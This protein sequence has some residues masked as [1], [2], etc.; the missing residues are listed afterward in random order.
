MLRKLRFGDPTRGRGKRG[1]LRVVYLHTPQ[2]ARVDLITVYGKE[3]QDDLSKDE[4][5]TLCELAR[6]L[7]AGL[8]ARARGESG[9]LKGK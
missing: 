2:A 8:I 3:E 6:S 7:R 4:L 9:G 1:G 5:G